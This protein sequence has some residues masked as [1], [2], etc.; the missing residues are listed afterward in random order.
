LDE[1]VVH[2]FALVAALFELEL[3]F[4]QFDEVFFEFENFLQIVRLFVHLFHRVFHELV[5]VS[6]GLG[7]VFLEG[8]TEGVEDFFE[9]VA[10]EDFVV[11]D[12]DFEAV[13]F[14]D[15]VEFFDF[16][17]FVSDDVVV[18]LPVFGGGEVLFDEGL[19][20]EVA[21]ADDFAEFEFELVEFLDGVVEFFVELFDVSLVFLDDGVVVGEVVFVVFEVSD[22]VGDFEEFFDFAEDALF[23]VLDRGV[24]VEASMLDD[25]L[26]G[27]LGDEGVEFFEGDAVLDFE[28]FIELEVPVV[29]PVGE[30]VG[31]GFVV[32]GDFV[33]DVSGAGE[34][35]LPLE[36]V[37]DQVVVEELAQQ[38]QNVRVGLFELA[39]FVG[40]VV[41]GGLDQVE[42]IFEVE[43]GVFAFG[44]G[45]VHLNSLAHFTSMDFRRG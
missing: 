10:D 28:D 17:S 7:E 45:E 29:S 43:F 27:H 30:Q 22:G 31:L 9:G 35:F 3:F 18:V 19:E 1:E 39:D 13:D 42:V 25:E 40:E 24:Q 12:V 20:V 16:L 41:G 44:Q 14:D 2:F 38:V 36:L 8:G 6:H 34:N 33:E 37:A 15:V 26:A 5:D 32:G 11:G 21:E 4:A 23:D